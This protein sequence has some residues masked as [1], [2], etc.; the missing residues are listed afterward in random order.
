[1]AVANCTLGNPPNSIY[2]V[3]KKG[4]QRSIP[5][6]TQRSSLQVDLVSR[7]T[8]LTSTTA[9][10]ELGGDLSV[11]SHWEGGKKG[12]ICCVFWDWAQ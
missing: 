9:F 6:Y 5:S 1:M 12:K 10:S 2:T 3:Y 11:R 8:I 7:S 4:N